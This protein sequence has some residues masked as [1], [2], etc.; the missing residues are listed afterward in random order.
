M[1][2]AQADMSR[3]ASRPRVNNF[4]PKRRANVPAAL[5]R[6]FS[7]SFFVRIWTDPATLLIRKKNK[8]DIS[9]NPSSI[10]VG[11]H[12]TNRRTFP[13]PAAR[14][15]ATVA[16][17]DRASVHRASTSNRGIFRRDD[18]GAARDSP[19]GN[20][21]VAPARADEERSIG[22]RWSPSSRRRARSSVAGLG[23]TRL[24][25]PPGVRRSRRD[26][27]DSA[28]DLASGAAGSPVKRTREGA[29]PDNTGP[30]PASV[31]AGSCATEEEGRSVLGIQRGAV[32]RA[33]AR[34]P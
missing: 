5:S 29:P 18:R 22:G 28:E 23:R 19:E 4:V 34:G 15:P 6:T 24:P 7:S 8:T 25:A 16:A 32:G 20:R 10:H 21:R 33:L 14:P 17:H 2:F 12:V 1:G 26:L 9:R 11:C 31:R 30:T 13:A 3:C 27:A